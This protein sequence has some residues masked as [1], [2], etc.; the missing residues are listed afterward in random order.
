MLHNALVNLLPYLPA[1]TASSPIYESK[2]GCFTDNRLYFYG[3]SQI[4]VPSITG[5]IIPEYISSFKEYER[6]II[7]TYSMALEKIE[8][9]SQASKPEHT[10]RS[11]S[12]PSEP[13]EHPSCK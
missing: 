10:R 12:Y 9:S 5:E 7:S 2:I 1:I 13:G 4:E 8:A 6:R 11:H 3:K